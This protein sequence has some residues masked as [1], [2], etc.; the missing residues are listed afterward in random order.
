MRR[1][2]RILILSVTAVAVIVLFVL[3]G[4]QLLA[5]SHQLSSTR[6]RIEMLD[7]ENAKLSAQAR[8]LRSDATVEQLA[9]QK[10]GLVKPGEQAY[11]VLPPTAAAPTSTTVAPAAP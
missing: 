2:V 7:Q 5:Q 9:R 1:T 11:V 10:Y 6:H 3:P 8:S 4:R